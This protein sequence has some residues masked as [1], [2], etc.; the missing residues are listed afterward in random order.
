MGGGGRNLGMFLS[1]EKINKLNLNV[2]IAGTEK[3]KGKVVLLLD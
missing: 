2:T 3:S 1:E